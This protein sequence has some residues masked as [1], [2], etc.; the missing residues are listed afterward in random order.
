MRTEDC[1]VGDPAMFHHLGKMN[2]CVITE[3][4]ENDRVVVTTDDGQ[5]RYEVAAASLFERP[6][7]HGV[8]IKI[9]REHLSRLLQDGYVVV[10]EIDASSTSA[11]GMLH[12]F[13]IEPI[14]QAN[15]L[16]PKKGLYVGMD[17]ELSFGK[18]R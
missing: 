3:I 11:Q 18:P 12:P 13:D 15:E 5:L 8:R 14:T 10:L 9:R 17:G 2:L 6:P 1:K 4:K 7:I 16:F